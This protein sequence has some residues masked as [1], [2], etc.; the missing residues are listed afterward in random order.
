MAAPAAPGEEIPFKFEPDIQKPWG[1]RVATHRTLPPP[2][3]ED[4]EA[5]HFDSEANSRFWATRGE[6]GNWVLNEVLTSHTETKNG[7][8]DDDLELAAQVGVN[9]GLELGPDG[10]FV[11]AL[12]ATGVLKQ[13]AK[14][15]RGGDGSF[16]NFPPDEYSKEREREWRL[17]MQVYLDSPVRANVPVY[18]LMSVSLPQLPSHYVVVAEVFDAPQ[19]G[20]DGT[21]VAVGR[22]QI[23]G[24]RDIRFK[25]AFNHIGPLMKKLGVSDDMILDDFMGKGSE[26]VELRSLKVYSSDYSGEGIFPLVTQRG[27]FPLRFQIEEIAG[28]I[29]APPIPPQPVDPMHSAQ[30]SQSASSNR[31]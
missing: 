13:L 8:P 11:K 28:A 26:T 2:S 14:N 16:D 29:S 5:L 6:N 18:S 3:G 15:Y 30:S 7:D 24:R 19:A 17:S 23:F 25:E 1:L 4:H 9:I 10:K 20:P 22:Q 27:T 31:G 21:P 12:D